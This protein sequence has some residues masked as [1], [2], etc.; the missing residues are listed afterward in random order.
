MTSD[1]IQRTI[2]RGKKLGADGDEEAAKRLPLWEIAYQLAVMNERNASGDQQAVDAMLKKVG[3]GS[4]V[5][6]DSDKAVRGSD[7]RSNR[8]N[9]DRWNMPDW[10]CKC[11]YAN[12]AIRSKCRN[13]ACGLPRPADERTT[14]PDPQAANIQTQ[15]L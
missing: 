8:N 10:V 1:E 13:F 14:R 6:A 12:R 7:E 9:L 2:D 11:G 4:P 5:G 15:E 3:L